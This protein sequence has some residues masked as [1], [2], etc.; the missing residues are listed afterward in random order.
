MTYRVATRDRET[1][2][3]N[4]WEPTADEDSAFEKYASAVSAYGQS[5]ALLFIEAPVVV[6]VKIA[7]HPGV[8]YP[9]E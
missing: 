2:Q 7:R 9:G 3:W 8:R 1:N 6:E 4:L 5:N